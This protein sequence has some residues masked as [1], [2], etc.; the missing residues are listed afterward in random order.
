MKYVDW[1]NREYSYG[2]YNMIEAFIVA[3]DFEME[4]SN[5]RILLL[6]EILLKEEGHPSHM[7]G[8]I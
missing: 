5:L 6:N 1:V 4:G 3:K 2:D 7:N 8:P